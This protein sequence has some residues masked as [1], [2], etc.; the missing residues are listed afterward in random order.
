M[1]YKHLLADNV[2]YI[3][4]TNKNALF[5]AA[6]SLG[7]EK[8]VK[9]LLPEIEDTTLGLQEA[10]IFGKNNIINT[11]RKTNYNKEKISRLA[12]LTKKLNEKINSLGITVKASTENSEL[13][14]LKDHYFNFLANQPKDLRELFK[15]AVGDKNKFALR[16]ARII[17]S[18]IGE[19]E[20]RREITGEDL[21][22]I[23][24]LIDKLT[25]SLD[26]FLDTSKN[27]NETLASFDKEWGEVDELETAL[28]TAEIKSSLKKEAIKYEELEDDYKKLVRAIVEIKETE[29]SLI[30][31]IN[32]I[33]E[34][35]TLETPIKGLE[36]VSKVKKSITIKLRPY[37]R[38]LSE[39]LIDTE[40]YYIQFLDKREYLSGVASGVV[41]ALNTIKLEIDKLLPKLI[42]EKKNT[43]EV[44]NEIKSIIENVESEEKIKGTIPP[45]SYYKVTERE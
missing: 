32:R 29:K 8:I 12:H 5:I 9:T 42:Q 17:H 44:I 25:L 20:F 37:L 23:D 41:R 27:I 33:N 6:C 22:D 16:L 43:E 15:Q 21:K 24:K 36:E 10:L 11:L 26:N 28:V 35:Y 7:K 3:D 19:E 2:K 30:D 14:E 18:A 31:N 1:N 39:V 45:S 13:K 4:K 38:E 34:E 40:K